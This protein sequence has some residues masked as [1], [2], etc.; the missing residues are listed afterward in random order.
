MIGIMSYEGQDL[1]LEIGTQ[2]DINRIKDIRERI[3]FWREKNEWRFKDADSSNY[4]DEIQNRLDYVIKTKDELSYPI[5]YIFLVRAPFTFGHSQ[6]VMNFQYDPAPNEADIFKEAAQ[7]IAKA[8]LMF[9]SQL[10]GETIRKFSDLAKLTLTEG[11]YIKTLILRTSAEEKTET[12]YK[13]HLVPY[14]KSHEVACQKRYSEIHHVNPYETGG[15]VGWL[16]ERETEVEKWE[17]KSETP[18]A[19]MLDEIMNTKF[20]LPELARLLA[21][22]INPNVGHHTSDAG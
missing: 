15:L 20:K 9:K 10:V 14:F 1:A 4:Y 13:V 17:L 12:T 16:G 5:S 7:I 18:W 3:W 8:L 6:L 2:V 21:V 11:I 22:S 19:V